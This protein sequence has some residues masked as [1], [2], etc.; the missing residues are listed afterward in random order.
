[1][2]QKAKADNRYYATMRQKD[3]LASE[4]TVLTKLAE[5]QQQKVESASEVQHS[6]STQLVSILFL[7]AA[8]H[9]LS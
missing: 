9:F 8:H 5:K 6:L 1:M 4:N 3:A 2:L 7:L